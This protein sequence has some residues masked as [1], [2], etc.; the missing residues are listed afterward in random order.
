MVTGLF[1]DY[2]CLRTRRKPTISDFVTMVMS[3][4]F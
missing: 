1:G 3:S 2:S 4:P